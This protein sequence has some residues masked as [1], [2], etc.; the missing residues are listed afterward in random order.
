MQA[1]GPSDLHV[2]Q[3]LSKYVSACFK[4]AQSRGREVPCYRPPV[5]FGEK[6]K[7]DRGER[8]MGQADCTISTNA[9]QFVGQDWK[10]NNVRC[11]LPPVSNTNVLQGCVTLAFSNHT[12]TFFMDLYSMSRTQI[13]RLPPHTTKKIRTFLL[14]RSI[15]WGFCL[16]NGL[17]TRH[18]C[19]YFPSTNY[20]HRS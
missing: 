18:S 8:F 10:N 15:V 14:L 6:A 5:V 4:Q 17:N 16:K 2:K 3:D 11:A 20:F 7:R 19:K 1:V 12:M 9:K 13:F